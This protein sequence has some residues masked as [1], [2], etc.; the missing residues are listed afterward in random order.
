MK[1]YSMTVF[2]AFEA[3]EKL[4]VAKLKASLESGVEVGPCHVTVMEHT[5][6]NESPDGYSL[7]GTAVQ[8][9]AEDLVDSSE[10]NERL[11]HDIGVISKGD[12]DIDFKAGSAATLLYAVN[13][14]GLPLLYNKAFRQQFAKRGAG[15]VNQA[16]IGAAIAWAFAIE[17]HKPLLIAGNT[18]AIVELYRKRVV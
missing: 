16:E 13:H 1:P 17:E 12:D 4:D 3:A 10:I 2:I 6:K 5:D 7:I 9:D 18:A 14:D 11:A 8:C 15:R